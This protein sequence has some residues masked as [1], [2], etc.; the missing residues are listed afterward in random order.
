MRCVTIQGGP[1]GP[2]FFILY[3]LLPVDEFSWFVG[4]FEGEG[5]VCSRT[6]R[7]THT[8]VSGERKTYTSQGYYI[9]IKMTDEDTIA[10]C[11]D[12]LGVKYAPTERKQTDA[13]GRKPLYRVRKM[14]T[15][16]G[17]LYQLLQRMRPHLSKRRQGQ[18]DSAL[19]N[20]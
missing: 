12:F 19:T 11:A 5:S 3:L 18:V 20:C 15:G 2:P 8:L 7:T 6:I 13:A 17:Q 10:R 1:P 16:E 4:I 14:G 9:T